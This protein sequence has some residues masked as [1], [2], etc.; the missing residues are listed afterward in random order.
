SVNDQT[1]QHYFLLNL[2]DKQIVIPIIKDWIIEL[3][4][5]EKYI[6]M[7]LPEGLMDVFLIPSKKD[8]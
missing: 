7:A 3:N 6:K 2:A 1:G 8:E 5:E 4:R